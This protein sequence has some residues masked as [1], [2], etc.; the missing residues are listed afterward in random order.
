MQVFQN[1]RAAF[2]FNQ[3]SKRP[4]LSPGK[5]LTVDQT[6]QYPQVTPN[7]WLHKSVAGG[8]LP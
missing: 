2:A 1:R 7:D 4:G 3:P 5:V 6:K 8:F